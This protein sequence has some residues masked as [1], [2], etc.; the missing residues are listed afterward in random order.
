MTDKIDLTGL[1]P[2]F[3][4]VTFFPETEEELSALFVC[5]LVGTFILFILISVGALLKSLKQVSWLTNLLKDEEP[6][7]LQLNR[8]KFKEESNRVKHKHQG[9]HLWLEFDETL[10]SV[11]QGDSV[12]LHNTLEASH[13][14][15]N[16]TLAPGITE[17]R[18][19]AA[20]PGFLTAFGVIG[21]FV[22]LQLGLAE[23]NIGNEVPVREMKAGLAGVISGAKIAFMTSV[24][25]VTLSVFFNISEKGLEKI[26][27]DKIH[28]LQIRIDGLFPRL[29]AEFQLHRIAEDGQQT[30]ESLQG[31]GEKIGEKL[32]ESLV[33]T[34]EV[35]QGGLES[36]LERIMAPAINKLVDETSSG[37]QKA[38]E[39]LVD[40]FL[41]RFGE[42]G[43]TQRDAM[44]QASHKVSDALGSL[45]S[46][47]STFLDRLEVSQGNSADRE[48][49]LITTISTQVTQLVDHS[50]EQ[51]RILTEFV[52]NQLS[53]LSE[54]FQE[55]EQSALERDQHRQEIFTE[56]SNTIKSSTE[57]LFK[58]VEEGLDTQLAASELLIEQGKVLQEG[59]DGSVK[60]SGL[61]SENLRVSAN[62]INSASQEIRMLGSHVSN[63]GTSLSGAIEKSVESATELAHQNKLSSEL[64]RQQRE[65]L[66]EDRQQFSQTIE[67]LQSL[68]NS[69]D[70]SFDKMR[71][72][73]GSFL[74]E[75][76]GNVSDLADQMTNLLKDYADQAN[77]QTERHLNE[78]SKHTT[79][80]AAAMNSA[81]QALS[82][83]VDEIEV[84]LGR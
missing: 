26:I 25:G 41:N 56:Q 1:F 13:F 83:V 59:I 37:N 70:S 33:E 76:K 35:L 19:L 12:K 7:T 16:S 67:R 50:N 80:Y 53:G 68:I 48:N 15:N 72:H 34:I 5:I 58:R 22:G 29:S 77:S 21:T 54:V 57:A 84:K 45:N 63:A 9:G 39:S 40:N 65:H 82:A 27:R 78:W 46:S 61:A 38:L 2:N 17:S 42:L 69:A 8:E 3:G 24:W 64:I 60:A 23:L 36:S 31:L 55:R 30:R 51:R 81:A 28:E 79:D 62:E 11:R 44:D 4:S 10:I 75:L 18:M 49:E 73:Q 47:M 66:I 32:Q 20:V 71:E 52:E 43:N 6:S 74:E 14:F